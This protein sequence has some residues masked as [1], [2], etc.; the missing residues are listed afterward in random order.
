LGVCAGA[1]RF[2]QQAA[3]AKTKSFKLGKREDRADMPKL[4][5]ERGELRQH[6]FWGLLEGWSAPRAAAAWRGKKMGCPEGQP[7]LFPP[8]IGDS[9]WGRFDTPLRSRETEGGA[10]AQG[11]RCDC[12]PGSPGWM[13]I[14]APE[15]TNSTRRFWA[16]PESVELSATGSLLPKPAA[17]TLV[18]GTFC[19][20]R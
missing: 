10:G 19:V 15:T 11:W 14:A 17:V 13:P 9:Y 7:I 6:D 1:A 20:S 16:R 12:A 2:R 8:A 18:S 4:Y 5:R 3:T